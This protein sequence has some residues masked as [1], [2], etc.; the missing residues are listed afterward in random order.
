MFKSKIDKI[1]YILNSCEINEHKRIK[2]FQFLK[3]KFRI[4]GKLD[5]KI[6]Y[7]FIDILIINKD[8]LQ[9]IYSII[10]EKI[11]INM[12]Q[13]CIKKDELFARNYLKIN[14]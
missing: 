3:S 6:L 10:E 1:K 4:N 2:L 7:K 12:L 13:D 11:N 8:D 9:N 14:D 5:I